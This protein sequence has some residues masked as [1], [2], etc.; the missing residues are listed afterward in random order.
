[1]EYTRYSSGGIVVVS[2][3]HRARRYVIIHNYLQDGGGEI[4][5]TVQVETLAA[6]QL[7]AQIAAVP[8]VDS[9]F[10]GPG[11]LSASMGFLGDIGRGEV[12]EQLKQ[13]AQVCRQLGK[14]C[15]IVGP[16]PELGGKFRECG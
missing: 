8:G 1:M 6:L 10:L 5:V 13:G 12:Q 2:A 7:L 4:F 16:N 9:I 3:W 11:D 14:P 15:G